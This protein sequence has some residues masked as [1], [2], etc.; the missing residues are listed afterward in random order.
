MHSHVPAESQ[1]CLL[2]PQG[3][4]KTSLCYFGTHPEPKRFGQFSQLNE[5]RQLEADTFTLQ[6]K[7]YLPVGRV[8]PRG[9]VCLA[10][11]VAAVVMQ[12]FQRHVL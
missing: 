4:V 10:K 9:V 1:K 11:S 8:Q 5:F 7:E 3:I 2:G 12:F 6:A